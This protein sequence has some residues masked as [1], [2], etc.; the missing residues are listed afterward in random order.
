MHIIVGTVFPRKNIYQAEMLVL[1][2][3][4]GLSNFMSM[5]NDLQKLKLIIK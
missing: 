4:I 3:F 5:S 2:F 1:S